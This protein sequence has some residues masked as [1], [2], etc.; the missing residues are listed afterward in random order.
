M[1]VRG[2]FK[3]SE[4]AAIG[5]SLSM[6]GLSVTIAAH[7]HAAEVHGNR[8]TPWNGG[9]TTNFTN[10]ARTV[11]LQRKLRDIIR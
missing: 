3:M 5:R 1:Y 10:A 2:D 6:T 11:S 4:P 7:R 8:E 9:P